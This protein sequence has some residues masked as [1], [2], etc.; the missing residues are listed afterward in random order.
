MKHRPADFEFNWQ[1]LIE[2]WRAGLVQPHIDGVSDLA[3]TS[4]VLARLA[5]REVVGKSVIAINP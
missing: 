2:W 5:Q 1:T 3:H 4:C